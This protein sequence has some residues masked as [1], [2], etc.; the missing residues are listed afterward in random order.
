MRVLT[1][2]LCGCR[3]AQEPSPETAPYA[4]HY[5][6]LEILQ[7]LLTTPISLLVSASATYCHL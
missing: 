4:S 1:I 5:R 2:S 3:S 7:K 6:A